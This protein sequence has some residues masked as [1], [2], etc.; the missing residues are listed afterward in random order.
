MWF[1]LV[2]SGPA[3]H[4][5]TSNISLFLFFINTV[6]PNMRLIIGVGKNGKIN[7]GNAQYSQ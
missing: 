1:Q 6:K 2:D 4:V 5:F 3:S 7:T